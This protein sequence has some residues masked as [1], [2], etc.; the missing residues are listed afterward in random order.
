METPKKPM[1]K[2]MDFVMPSC[3]I[4]SHKISESM[5]HKLSLAD[6]IRVQMHLMVCDLCARYRDQL[7]AVQNMIDRYYDEDTTQ[8]SDSDPKLS[9]EARTRIVE[10]MHKHDH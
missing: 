7:F 8:G 1:Q 10:K 5:D 9:E 3:E 6:R 2:M 4:V